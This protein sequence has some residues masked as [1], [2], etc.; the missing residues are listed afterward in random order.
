MGIGYLMRVSEDKLQ[1]STGTGIGYASR[2]AIC[3]WSS[4]RQ[5]VGWVGDLTNGHAME[6]VCVVVAEYEYS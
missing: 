2:S 6:C 1:G 4:E 3:R 5:T